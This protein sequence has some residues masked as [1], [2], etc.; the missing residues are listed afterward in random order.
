MSRQSG[1]GRCGLA[2]ASAAAHSGAGDELIAFELREAVDALGEIVGRTWTDDILD[3][4]FSRFC[5]GK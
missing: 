1:R 2:A 5:I 4:I 3:R